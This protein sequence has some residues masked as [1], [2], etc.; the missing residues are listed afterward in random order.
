M[1]AILHFLEY[2]NELNILKTATL[3]V[4][5]NNSGKHK[6]VTTFHKFEHSCSR[7]DNS[8]RNEKTIT[9]T[10]VFLASRTFETQIRLLVNR[11]DD[12]NN[13]ELTKSFF[14]VFSKNRN[15]GN[16]YCTFDSPAKLA[17][18]SKLKE[19]KPLPD[20]KIN[21]RHLITCFRSFEIFT[22]TQRNSRT[23]RI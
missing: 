15:L 16:L 18:L 20:R 22:K 5:N 4:N 23:R 14:L 13:Y 11:I 1:Y 8:D 10:Q 9:T 17:L 2:T 3:S 6:T 7:D 12:K 19:V 21:F